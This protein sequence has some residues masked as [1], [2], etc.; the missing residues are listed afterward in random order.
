MAVALI[1]STIKTVEWEYIDCDKG[2]A[3]CW[4]ALKDHHQSKGL[5]QQVQLVQEVLT[6]HCTKSTPH[7]L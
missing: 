7:S 3:A 4:S 1:S 2:A 5:I 6:T